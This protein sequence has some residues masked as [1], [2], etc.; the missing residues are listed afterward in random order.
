MHAILALAASHLG[1]I[2]GEDLGTIAMHHRQLAIRGSNEAISQAPR[3]GS[4]GDALLASCYLIA[5]QSTYMPDG[6]E[7]TFRMFRGCTMLNHQLKLEK[8]PMGFFCV[9]HFEY[10]LEN[11]SNVPLIDPSLVTDSQ[12]SLAS[13]L[14]I[15][16]NPEEIMFHTHLVEIGDLLAVSSVQ[17]KPSPTLWI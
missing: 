5:F 4:T 15:I 1:L 14:P 11:L 10:M 9:D 16:K 7:E 6:M 17:G 12:K 2:T 3:T 13:L 8:L